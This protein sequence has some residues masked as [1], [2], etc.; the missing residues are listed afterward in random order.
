MKLPIRG[1]R[2][3][4]SSPY[5]ITAEG[6]GTAAPCDTHLFL[7]GE[8]DDDTFE[9]LQRVAANTCYLHQTMIQMPALR[10]DLKLNGAA[11]QV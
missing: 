1:I 10:V 8:T 2:L 6:R 11:V 7:N 9:M 3:V 5:G 4:Q